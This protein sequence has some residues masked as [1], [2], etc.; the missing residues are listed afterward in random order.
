MFV[1]HSIYAQ[2][3]KYASGGRL[4]LT[5]SG[6]MNSLLRHG[7]EYYVAGLR[8]Y[9]VLLTGFDCSGFIG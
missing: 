9:D 3:K 6:R 7:I 5:S 4:K 1:M 2:K 8:A